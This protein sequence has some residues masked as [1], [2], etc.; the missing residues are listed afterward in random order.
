M[1]PDQPK[2]RPRTRIDTTLTVVTPWIRSHLFQLTMADLV[3]VMLVTFINQFYVC[4]IC[5]NMMVLGDG[6]AEAESHLIDNKIIERT[7]VTMKRTN[8]H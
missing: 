6:Q 3:K 2:Q 1:E 8:Q 4:S 7:F 5:T